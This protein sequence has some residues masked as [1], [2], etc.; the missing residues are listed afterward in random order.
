VGPL[1]QQ[2]IKLPLITNTARKIEPT[3]QSFSSIKQLVAHPPTPQSPSW[4]C[5][6]YVH[7][8]IRYSDY[9][10]GGGGVGIS[11]PLL[12]DGGDLRTHTLLLCHWR[13]S[14]S[15]LGGVG[16]E[17]GGRGGSAPICTLLVHFHHLPVLWRSGGTPPYICSLS[18]ANEPCKARLQNVV[19]PHWRRR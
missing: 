11:T 6:T 18:S 17:G 14:S 15:C 2:R 4:D 5:D 7:M 3:T 19:Q 1:S 10:G 13:R 9:W 8:T 12:E 16:G